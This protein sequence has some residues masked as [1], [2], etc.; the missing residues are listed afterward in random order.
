[1]HNEPVKRPVNGLTP[2]PIEGLRP[3]QWTSAGR[4]AARFLASSS[5]GSN[6]VPRE[7]I[8]G[9]K[10]LLGSSAVD[11]ETGLCPRVDATLQVHRLTAL[12]VEILGDPG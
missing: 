3:D 7:F 6:P 11:W 5:K 9:V 2:E 1:M 12:R 10:P 4:K 8:E